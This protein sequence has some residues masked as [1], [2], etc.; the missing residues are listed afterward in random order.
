M[1]Q[2]INFYKIIN[3][4]IVK[5]KRGNLTFCESNK[6]IPFVIK[7]IYYLYDIPGGSLRAGH[8]HKKLHQ[9]LISLSGSFE[10]H[11][12]NGVEKKIIHLNR[13]YEALYI[14]PNVWRILKNFSSGAVCLALAS[15]YF[16][17]KDYIRNYTIFQNYIKK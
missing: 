8:S 5:D 4:P 7:R 15:D 17:E 10:V 9:C 1:K 12:D 6:H 14:A 11:L 3:L 2:K 16:Y 13:C